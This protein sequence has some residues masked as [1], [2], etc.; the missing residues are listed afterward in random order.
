MD[1]HVEWQRDTPPPGGL[2][3]VVVRMSYDEA[4]DLATGGDSAAVGEAI[5]DAIT[6]AVADGSLVLP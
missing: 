3:S 6:T 5:A 1:S 2:V 4:A